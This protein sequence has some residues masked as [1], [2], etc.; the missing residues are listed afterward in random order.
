MTIDPLL[1]A[2]LP[3][4]AV[5]LAIALVA[6][7][8]AHP[9]L[10]RKP[11]LRKEIWLRYAAWVAIAALVL[12]GLLLG[13]VPWIL[14]VGLLS[15]A[16]FREYAR[17]VGLWMDWG[18][19]AVVYLFICAVA[20]SSASLYADDYPEP[21]WYGLFIVLPV[22]GILA[23]LLVPILRDRAWS[24][25]QRLSLAI[26]GLLYFGFFLG[27][28]G[29]LVNFRGGVG[30]VLFLAFLTATNDVAAFV[31]GRLAG[32]HKLR[33]HLSPGKTVEGALG[34]LVA[35]LL[36]G[37]GLRFLVPALPLQHVLIAS[38]LI[39]IA[40]ITG[41]LALATIKRDLGI[42]DWSTAL[43]GHGGVLDRLNSLM[44]AAPVFFHYVRFFVF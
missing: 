16:A 22:Y 44:L 3:R 17:A 23:L 42:K 41:D 11:E 24:M 28:F 4:L 39:A 20:A 21:G 6:I 33:P 9:F 34:G 10:A 29:Y 7:G 37:Y 19:Q 36:A 25:L 27:H 5:V 8:I 32:R 30:L 38:A 12:G 14:L 26:L 43:P 13:R 40:G 35:T 1:L 18:L 15:V 2:F 31:V